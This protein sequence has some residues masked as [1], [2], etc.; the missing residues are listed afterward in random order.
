MRQFLSTNEI[1]CDHG[2]PDTAAPHT[3]PP[4]LLPGRG[5]PKSLH[6]NHCKNLAKK[7]LELEVQVF[8][9]LVPV[10][11]IAAIHEK[12]RPAA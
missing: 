8:K 2:D 1:L 4:A 6:K 3:H 9:C 10:A 5:V 12:L 7:C 11:V